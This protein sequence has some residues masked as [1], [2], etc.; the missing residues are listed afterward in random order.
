MHGQVE[1]YEEEEEEE[2]DEDGSDAKEPEPVGDFRDDLEKEEQSKRVIRIPL[3]RKKKV[4]HRFVKILQ[5]IEKLFYFFVSWE[6]LKLFGGKHLFPTC[7][8]FRLSFKIYLGKIC[9]GK[10]ILEVATSFP[11]LAVREFFFSTAN[12]YEAFLYI[13]RCA[14]YKR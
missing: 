11:V 2:Q 5:V 4:G 6:F 10:E 12:K 8:H 3:F 9:S 13:R 7:N 14:V 1:E